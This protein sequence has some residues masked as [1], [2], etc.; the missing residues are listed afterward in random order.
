MKQNFLMP[1]IL[2]ATVVGTSGCAETAKTAPS[3]FPFPQA[4]GLDGAA[5]LSTGK[6]ISDHIVSFS[7]GKNCSTVRKNIGQ[8]YCEEDEV[9]NPD[10]VF[11]YN[12]LGNVTCYASPAPHGETQR[13]LGQSPG[14]KELS[15]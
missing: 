11:C 2:I 12:T 7:T 15:R 13:H 5:V 14:G 9:G 1:V 10:E 8:H 6:T 3:F 4:M